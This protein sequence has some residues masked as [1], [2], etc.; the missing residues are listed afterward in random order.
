MLDESGSRVSS[1]GPATPVRIAGLKELPRAGDELIGVASEVRAREVYEFRALEAHAR[2][3]AASTPRRG[4][5]KST[6]KRV[7]LVLKASRRDRA[8]IGGDPAE[9]CMC[10]PRRRTPP[11]RSRR[12]VRAS[13]TS[14]PSASSCSSSAHP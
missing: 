2:E 1:A 9:I 6:A 4:R 12:R 5:R 14:Q 3:L 10:S 13:H 7:P 11:A 8:E